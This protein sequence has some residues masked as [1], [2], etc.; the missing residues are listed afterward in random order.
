[1]GREVVYMCGAADPITKNIHF[2]KFKAP[3]WLLHTHAVLICLFFQAMNCQAKVLACAACTEPEYKRVY[4]T[5]ENIR[6]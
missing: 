1:M 6:V 3:S 4:K 5:P 2:R